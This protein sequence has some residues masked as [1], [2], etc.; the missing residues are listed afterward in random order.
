MTK[1]FHIFIPITKVDEEKRLVYGLA[2]AEKVDKSGEIFDYESSKPFYQKW[3]GEIHKA[4]G[5]KSYGNVRE[6]HTNIA[7][8]KLEQ[9][10]FNDEE[11]QVEVCA[12]VVDDSSWNKVLEGVLTGFSHGGSY[13]KTWKDKENPKLTRYT[14]QPSE[15]SLVD[16]PCLGEATFELIRANGAHEMVKFKSIKENEMSQEIIDGKPVQPKYKPEQVWK[17]SDGQTFTKKDE[18]RDYELKL[19]KAAEQGKSISDLAQEAIANLGKALDEKEKDGESEKSEFDKDAVSDAEAAEKEDKATDEQKKLLA[20]YRASKEKD[21]K[22]SVADKIKKSF[23]DLRKGYSEAWDAKT[24]IEALCILEGLM[25]G[26]EW[27]AMLGEADG[28]QIADLKEAINRIKSFIA[29]EIMEGTGAGDVD[30]MAM[31]AK[32]DV[33]T[34]EEVEYVKKT[35]V[36]ELL[37]KAGK[38]HSK[39]DKANLKKAAEFLDGNIGHHGDAKKAFGH[40]SKAL[41][42]MECAVEKAQET[43]SLRKS[44]D[45]KDKETKEHLD[46]AESQ[47]GKAK[48]YIGKIGKSND[49]MDAGH[50]GMGHALKAVGARDEDPEET[51]EEDE[52]K[53]AVQAEL[54]KSQDELAKTVSD[55]TVSN[56]ALTQEN[57]KLSETLATMVKTIGETTER[58]KKLEAQPLPGKGVLY[59]TSG[60]MSPVAKGHEVQPADAPVEVPAG[61]THGASPE[62]MRSIMGMSR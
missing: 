16:N 26:E 49:G 44:E 34:V 42:E 36:L 18:W 56:E 5:G 12:K 52:V 57:A 9:I 53:K 48:K 28:A 58:I 14:A 46:A 8:G 61:I 35:E 10:V 41:D 11:K 17:A 45:E 54:K 38:R 62:Q 33:S 7:A 3:S 23:E 4:S 31:C 43:F 32:L 39:S 50:D 40:I 25:C 19:E 13:I 27:E 30:V 21:A 20:D 6:M 1:Q 24:A 59:D 47:L 51:E 29:S 55:L 22:K 37:G 60:K 15:L 2:T